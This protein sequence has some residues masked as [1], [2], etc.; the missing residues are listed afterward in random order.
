MAKAKL[1][2]V[3]EDYDRVRAL[4]DGSVEIPDYSLNHSFLPPMDMFARLFT[5][6]EFDISEMSFGAYLVALSRG[7]SNKTENQKGAD[8]FPYVGL[9][10][11]PSRVFAHSS[12]Y[13]RTDRGID[14]PSDLKGKTIGI[15][16][17]QFTR[18]LCARGMLSDEY[19]ITPADI[20]WRLAGVDQPQDLDYQRITAPPGVDLA[21]LGPDATLSRALTDGDI[22]AMISASTPLCYRRR[23]PHIGRLFPDFR[24]VEQAYF[25]KTGIF[26]IMHL[27]AV[28]TSLVEA[29]PGLPR[30]LVDAFTRA[31]TAVMPHLT[32]LDALAVHLPWL[33]AEAEATIALMGEDFWPYGLAANRAAL[34]TQIRWAHEQGLATRRFAVEELFHPSTL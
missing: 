7:S 22:D 16:N 26:P 15:P 17:Y 3:T 21:A 31:K 30:A 27:V 34:E 6:H 13:V 10:I 32:E 14:Q 24:A 8:A 25:K 1:T 29:N 5:K 33:V 4:H 19:G 2:L 9:P 12:I 20:V 11:F 18:G 28:R 23:A